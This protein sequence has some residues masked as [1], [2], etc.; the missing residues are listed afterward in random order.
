[1]LLVHARTRCFRSAPSAADTPRTPEP[2]NPRWAS[3]IHRRNRS[4]PCTDLQSQ[5][6]CPLKPTRFAVL[7]FVG[8]SGRRYS[9]CSRIRVFEG[10]H[11]GMSTA[12][13]S[14][15]TQD[16]STAYVREIF[17]SLE[18]GDGKASWIIMWRTTWIGSS[19]EHILL[20]VT[21]TARQSS[22]RMPLKSWQRPTPRRRVA[23][24]TCTRQRSLGGRRAAL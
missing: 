20:P 5:L 6:C 14:A 19:R 24:G 16:L 13:R 23:C 4:G 11:V 2:T 7:H 17:K 3:I 9:L 15:V 1:M 22:S 12:A 8:A 18:S 10:G 21:I